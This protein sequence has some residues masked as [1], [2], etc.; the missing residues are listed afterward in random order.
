MKRFVR[1]ALFIPTII[2]T[3]YIGIFAA[4]YFFYPSQTKRVGGLIA[5]VDSDLIIRMSDDDFIDLAKG[6]SYDEL[7]SELGKPSGTFGSGIVSYYWRI[8]ENKY[9]VVNYS[10]GKSV[11]IPKIMTGEQE[12]IKIGF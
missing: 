6:R 12:K 8:G 9:G 11:G 4:L 5:F 3:T 1:I 7:V 10:Y 2:I